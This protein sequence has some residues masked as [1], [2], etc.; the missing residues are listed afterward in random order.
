MNT[1]MIENETEDIKIER[2]ASAKQNVY[3]FSFIACVISLYF[4]SFDLK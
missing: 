1:Y 4:N 3:I 2:R